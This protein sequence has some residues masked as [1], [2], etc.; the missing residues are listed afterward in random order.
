[1]V[2]PLA[3][4]AQSVGVDSNCQF[5]KRVF[6]VLVG[7]FPQKSVWIV[8]LAYIPRVAAGLASATKQRDA[9]E[10]NYGMVTKRA[11][12]EAALAQAEAARE[13]LE[14]AL[15]EAKA[16]L[17][18]TVTDASTIDANREE[19][20]VKVEKAR[21]RCRQLRAALADPGRSEL[22]TRSRERIDALVGQSDESP[23][24][25]ASQQQR[26][27]SERPV[28]SES[29]R[30]GYAARLGRR[31]RQI[32]GTLAA[33]RSAR[34]SIGL[35]ALVLAYL[36]FY[37]FDVNLQIVTLPSVIAWAAR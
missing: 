22:I 3:E 7:I 30:S 17:V 27:S 20:S 11:E 4:G 12:L 32:N 10:R 28:G 23:K 1:M 25:A 5:K 16:A 18:N 9:R 15:A 31:I 37:Y 6:C 21:A 35:S 33:S 13:I 8:R 14:A 19:A 34:E 2:L 29:G 26:P 36:Q 24:L